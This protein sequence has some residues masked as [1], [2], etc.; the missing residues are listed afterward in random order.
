MGYA[1][2]YSYVRSFFG[3]ADLTIY[4]VHSFYIYICNSYHLFTAHNL[5]RMICFFFILLLL[6]LENITESGTHVSFSVD[7]N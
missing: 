3:I 5:W 1:Q 7:L 6:D 4:S 2:E